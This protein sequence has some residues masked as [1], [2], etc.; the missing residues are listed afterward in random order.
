MTILRNIKP[1]Y[2]RHHSVRYTDAALQACVD[3]TERYLTERSFPDKAI[4]VLDEAGSKAHL[5]AAVEP[6]SIAR[7]ERGLRQAVADR[8]RAVSELVYEQA[9]AARLRE[10]ALTTKL[11]EC[12]TR[13][14]REL[15]M[16][17]VTVD[18]EQ[19]EEVIT[20][21]TGIPVE[22]VSQD[23]QSRLRGMADHLNSV[24]VGQADAVE[25]VTR[26]IQRSRAGLKEAGRP[27]GVFMFVGPTGVGKTLLAKELARWMFDRRD[28]LIR[29]DM[30]EYSEKHNVARLIGSPPGYV[31]YGEGG[32][33]TEAVRRHPYSVVLFDEIE[34]AHSD[35]FN[36]ML[37]IFDEGRL[38]DGSGRVVDFRNT[39]IVITSNVGSRA[40][41]LRQP[42]VG[43]STPSREEMEQQ[44]DTDAYRQALSRTFAPE[45]INRIDD[46]VIF[47]TLDEQNIERIVD[48]ELEN[49]RRRAEA[50]GIS[51]TVS[52]GARRRLARMGYEERYGVRSLKRKILDSVE[53]PMA[54]MIVEGDLSA[55]DML[56]VEDADDGLKLYRRC[57]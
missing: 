48:L 40:A 33:L 4:D 50:L 20:L 27:I 49:L 21:I 57:A 31:G 3:L 11:D 29:I 39:V 13:W 44:G 38:T 34:K 24:V 17:P 1:Q 6:E 32:Q 2:E 26:A 15:R 42:R 5:R 7:I 35:V 36:I 47:R 55:G 16:Y 54:R 14:E 19:I 10:L 22:K 53:E 52:E 51:I 12:R 25:R 46:I 45:F 9:A 23:E 30:S 18:A 41:A 28:G 37:Q 56:A 8:R 43:Y